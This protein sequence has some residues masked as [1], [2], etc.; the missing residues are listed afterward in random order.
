MA[1]NEKRKILVVDDEPN[2][3][4]LLSMMLAKM[5]HEPVGAENAVQALKILDRGFDL[6]LSDVMMP[7]M[8]GFGFVEAIRGDPETTD[9]PVIMVT[10]LNEKQDRLKA[11][12]SGANDFIS[13]PIDYLELK[14]RVKSLLKVKAHQD[15]IRRYQAELSQMVEQRTRELRSALKALKNSSYDVIHILSTAAEFKDDE[16]S[17]HIRR[18]SLY[19]AL[20]AARLG[21]D[22]GEEELILYASPMHDVGKIGIPDSILLKPG[23]LDPA[24]WQVMRKHPEIGA[25]ILS[26]SDSEL[27]AKAGEIALS[28]HEK[29]D[30]SGYPAGIAGED[31]PLSGRICAVADVFDALTTRRVYKEAFSIEKSVGIMEE[32][33]GEHFDPGVL[34]VFLG[35]LDAALE[36]KAAVDRIALPEYS[37]YRSLVKN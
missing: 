7:E 17:S 2:N 6:V 15:E 28:H 22:S 20:I 29:W 19:S 36:I 26:S 5:G 34:D 9:L 12:E 23:K 14:V 33:R 8:D 16:T 24:E 3:V 11:V 18:M 32:G 35:N 37:M 4:M 30:G 10:T 21:L 1:E 27:I 31:I 25:E 13:K